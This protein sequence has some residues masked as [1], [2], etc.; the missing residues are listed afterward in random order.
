ML[1]ALWVS[2]TVSFAVSAS[3]PA[4]TVTV[5]AVFQFDVVKVRV[6]GSGVTSVPA[7]PATVTFAVGRVSRTTV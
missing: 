6:T 7:C 4:V 3:L 2:E 5:W 1:V